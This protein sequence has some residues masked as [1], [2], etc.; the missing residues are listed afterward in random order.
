MLVKKAN[1]LCTIACNI[2]NYTSGFMTELGKYAVACCEEF[3]YY[4]Q[5]KEDEYG[6]KKNTKRYLAK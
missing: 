4:N 3:H 1:F 6:F 2:N 5:F